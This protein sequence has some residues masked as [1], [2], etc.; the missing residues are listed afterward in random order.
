MNGV[1]TSLRSCWKYL[2]TTNL[3]TL[4]NNII[5][6]KKR[7]PRSNLKILETS[8]SYSCDK[9]GVLKHVCGAS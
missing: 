3:G 9:V 1:P 6:N 2:Y 4:V 7:T 5:N 8:R